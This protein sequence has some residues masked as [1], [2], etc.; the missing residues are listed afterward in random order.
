M[1]LLCNY[2]QCGFQ[3]NFIAQIGM[4]TGILLNKKL[5][6]ANNLFFGMKKLKHVKK[7]GKEKEFRKN[8]QLQMKES[9]QMK[10]ENQNLNKN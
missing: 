4:L 3:R 2:I 9:Q 6:I 8:L 1:L 7:N 10:K 5:K